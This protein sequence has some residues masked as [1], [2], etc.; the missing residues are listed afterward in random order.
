M[1]VFACSYVA[2]I[3]V[4]GQCKEE[5]SVVS[6]R[7][8]WL[9]EPQ[10]ACR[11]SALG[12]VLS[13]SDFNFSMSLSTWSSLETHG[14]GQEITLRLLLRPMTEELKNTFKE[15]SARH[16]RSQSIIM[17]V[18]LNLGRKFEVK[19]CCIVTHQMVT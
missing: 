19:M 7:S 14:S 5:R 13:K 6:F 2:R 16:G 12:S 3:S 17:Q 11:F 1:H 4:T 8:A 18:A 9:V 10:K 15:S